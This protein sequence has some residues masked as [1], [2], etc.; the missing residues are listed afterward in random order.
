MN[1]SVKATDVVELAQ[2]KNLSEWLAKC[3]GEMKGY[4]ELNHDGAVRFGD[5]FKSKIAGK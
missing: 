2:Y 5:Y 3:K 4:A 1:R